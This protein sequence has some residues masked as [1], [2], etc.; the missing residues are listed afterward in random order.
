MQQ[1]KCTMDFQEIWFQDVCQ[2]WSSQTIYVHY[3]LMLLWS[4]VAKEGQV[5]KRDI[6]R[7]DQFIIW[8][9]LLWQLYD[10]MAIIYCKLGR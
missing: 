3:C 6:V 9:S 4:Y 5:I 2:N 10:S 1:S 7:Q 8:S